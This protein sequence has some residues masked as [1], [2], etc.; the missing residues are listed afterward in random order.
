MLESLRVRDFQCHRSL[1]LDLSRPV[2]SLVG[3]TNRGKSAALRALRWLALN[4][5][6][7]EAFVRHGA[8]G[9]SV[10][11]TL[12]GGREVVRERGEKNAYRL[13][14]EE[15]LA[16]GTGVPGPIADL[17]DV[18]PENFAR[19]FDAHFWL[20]LSPPQAA[21]ELNA[22]VALDRIDDSL[23]RVAS[24]LRS[25]K[26]AVDLSEGQLR[27][28]E[29]DLSNLDHVDE[30]SND[31]LRLE[32]MQSDILEIEQSRAA[33][34]SIL[35]KGEFLQLEGD[36]LSNVVSAR[37]DGISLLEGTMKRLGAVREER[38]ALQD[39][40]KRILEGEERV[41][42]LATRRAD[43]ARRLEEGRGEGCPLCGSPTPIPSV[44]S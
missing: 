21:R 28:A 13:D 11:L 17:L 1:D 43:A 19:Q 31:L 24:A 15:Y 2:V 16:F 34:A 35:E 3:P 42:C 25:A 10:V 6:G 14:G 9:C 30:L 44:S 40:I 36:R 29:E 37:L 38:N 27:A 23:S 8:E 26:A 20:S 39:M 22:V 18:G 12:D 32:G 5:P 41:S 7:G 4:L 33:L